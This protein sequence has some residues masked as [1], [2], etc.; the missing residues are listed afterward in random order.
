MD[1]INDILDDVALLCEYK[2]INNEK[3]LNFSIVI[4]GICWLFSISA[5]SVSSFFKALYSIKQT[6]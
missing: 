2:V 5:A 3:L 1:F 4:G 6:N